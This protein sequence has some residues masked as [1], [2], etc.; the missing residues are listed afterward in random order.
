MTPESEPRCGID[1]CIYHRTGC[2][3][4]GRLL[5]DTLQ[6]VCG[7]LHIKGTTAVCVAPSLG[8]EPHWILWFETPQSLGETGFIPLINS[9]WSRDHGVAK[10]GL[11]KTVSGLPNVLTAEPTTLRSFC[12]DAALLVGVP[13][14]LGFMK[15]NVLA[16]QK[17]C[18]FI[19]M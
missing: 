4:S 1:L 15:M 10:S 5:W 8:Y 6:F 17:S 12:D 18:R 11:A 9:N 16:S 2:D 3:P 14:L 7:K 13:L 19:S